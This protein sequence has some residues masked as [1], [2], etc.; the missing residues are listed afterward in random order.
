MRCYFSAS[1][2]LVEFYSYP[3][4]YVV[5]VTAVAVSICSIPRGLADPKNGIAFHPSNIKTR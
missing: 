2:H 4:E 3:I 5:P 1:R